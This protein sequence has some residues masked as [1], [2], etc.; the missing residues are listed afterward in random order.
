MGFNLNTWKYKY[1]AISIEQAE[2]SRALSQDVTNTP[3]QLCHQHGRNP[4]WLPVSHCEYDI[5]NKYV[6]QNYETCTSKL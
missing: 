6:S 2:K 3:A 5:E 4:R 1:N